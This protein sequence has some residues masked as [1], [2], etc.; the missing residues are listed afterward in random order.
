MKTYSS[1]KLKSALLVIVF[2]LN[3]I[4]GFAC[5]IGL[6][7][8]FKEGVFQT[9]SNLIALDLHTSEE[10]SDH[11]DEESEDPCCKDEVEKFEKIDKLAP[12]SSDSGLSPIISSTFLSEYYHHS[13]LFTTILLPINRYQLLKHHPP[14]PD[15][16]IARQSF[17]I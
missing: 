17:Q 4:I 5:S 14:I 10:V 2:F 6:D 13:T 9:G 16:R 3:T 8:V 11:H 1:I 15:I 7:T 12:Q